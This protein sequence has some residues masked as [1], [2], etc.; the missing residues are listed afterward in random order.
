MTDTIRLFTG[1]TIPAPARDRLACFMDGLRSRGMEDIRWEHPDNLH[2]TLNFLG[3][4]PLGAEVQV[5][6]DMR[7]VTRTFPALRTGLRGYSIFE[8][9]P[10]HRSVIYARL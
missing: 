5:L 10:P 7:T 4:C 9:E 3:D 1:L 6:E 8:N 2:L